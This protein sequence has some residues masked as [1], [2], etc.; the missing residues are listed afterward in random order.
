MEIETVDDLANQ[1]AD[2][3]GVYGCCKRA[4]TFEDCCDPNPL[5]CRIGFMMVF[6][7]R[8]RQAVANDQ[9]LQEVF[10]NDKTKT[11]D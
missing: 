7:D 3:L 4:E 9:K 5:C 8:I 2:W 1:I 6:P 10:F 11:H